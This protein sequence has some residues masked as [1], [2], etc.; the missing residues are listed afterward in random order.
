MKQKNETDERT[1]LLFDRAPICCL[2]LDRD[3]NVHDCNQE[4]LEMF[5]VPNKQTFLDNFF[6]FSPEFQPCGG[7]SRKMATEQNLKALSEGYSRFE[8]IHQT[9]D[10]EAIPCEVTLVHVT[11][12]DEH[13]AACYIRDLREH[14]E[15][16]DRIKNENE[17]YKTMAHWYESLLDA[18]PFMVTAQDTSEK[19]TFANASTEAF[20]GK[21]RDEI[22]G[23]PCKNWDLSICKTDECAIACAKRGQMR[24]Y[25]SHENTSYQ[26][27]VKMLEDLKGES[28]GYV[29]IIQDI[30]QMERMMK[31]QAE[32]EAADSAKASFLSAMSHEMRTPM[33]A[34]MGMTAVGKEAHDLEG[35]NYALEKVE[36]AS[37]QLL[38]LINDVLDITNIGADRFELVQKDFDIRNSIQKALLFSRPGMKEKRLQLKINLDNKIPFLFVGD[39]QRLTQ[40]IAN[41]LSNAVKFTPTEGKINFDISLTGENSNVY[42]LCFEIADTGIGISPEQHRR[43]FDAFEQGERGATRRYGGTGLG[44]FISKRIVELMGGRI[45]VESEPGKGARFFFTVKLAHGKKES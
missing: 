20:L 33:S 43:I 42:E 38:G 36:E 3:F 37:K 1:Q 34:I 27:D 8:W 4:T 5:K 22:T 31:Q 30:T 16:L 35:K 45:W 40:V 24:T 7:N 13:V 18:I 29:E 6:N 14:K 12:K 25:F 39:D 2:L 9:L 11:Y 23:I 15:L 19:W 10:G 32:S 28:A 41:L 26:V 21:N 44:L 17:R